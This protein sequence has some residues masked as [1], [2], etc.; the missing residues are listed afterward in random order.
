MVRELGSVTPGW[1]SRRVEQRFVERVV[2]DAK[3]RFELM[4]RRRKMRDTLA[5]TNQTLRGEGETYQAKY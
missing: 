1:R 5:N 4:L 3:G 2:E